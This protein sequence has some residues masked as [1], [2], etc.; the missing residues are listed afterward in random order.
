MDGD[1]EEIYSTLQTHGGL[2]TNFKTLTFMK[3]LKLK[4]ELQSVT[5]TP[6]LKKKSVSN[7]K[8]TIGC[9]YV[10]QYLFSIITPSKVLETIR[11]PVKH[12]SELFLTWKFYFGM[13]NHNWV[14]GWLNDEVEYNAAD[15][16]IF[17]D[18]LDGEPNE[19]KQFDLDM[20]LTFCKFLFGNA[21][22]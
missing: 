20:S 19:P 12:F 15:F 21:R 18:Y 16:I 4:K 6:N 11:T 10:Q 17:F 22:S 14:T 7:I 2:G 5:F 9:L 3:V 8:Y 13:L 1:L